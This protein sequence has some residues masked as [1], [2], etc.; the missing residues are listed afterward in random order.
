M[1]VSKVQFY[2]WYQNL[3]SLDRKGEKISSSVKSRDG[4]KMELKVLVGLFRFQGGEQEGKSYQVM[5]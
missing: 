3:D 4:V 5:Q 2:P 1:H